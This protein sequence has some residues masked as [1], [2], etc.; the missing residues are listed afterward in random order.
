MSEQS[1]V[2][3][4]HTSVRSST[5]I[6]SDINAQD[7]LN[8]GKSNSEDDSFQSSMVMDYITRAGYHIGQAVEYETNSQYEGAFASYKAAISSLLSGIQGEDFKSEN[9][10]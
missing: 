1:H 5:D 4:Q 8:T 2:R 7:S 9:L 6:S 10:E 3:A